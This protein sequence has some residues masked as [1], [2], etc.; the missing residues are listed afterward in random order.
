MSLTSDVTAPPYGGT[1]SFI[2]RVFDD[3]GIQITDITPYGNDPVYIYNLA[4]PG[5]TYMMLPDDR[6][7][8]PNS[9]Y[10]DL[11]QLEAQSFTT[12]NY[13][14]IPLTGTT[15][16]GV[17]L[18]IEWEMPPVD[19]SKTIITCAELAG[20]SGGFSVHHDIGVIP[21]GSMNIEL[22]NNENEPYLAGEVGP[23][24]GL[25]GAFYTLSPSP[26]GL[27]HNTTDIPIAN[28]GFTPGQQFPYGFDT[29][30]IRN[31]ADLTELEGVFSTTL[32]YNGF[33][34]DNSVIQYRENNGS[35]TEV[36]IF[37]GTTGPP[38][39]FNYHIGDVGPNFSFIAKDV[40][41]SNYIQS[42][43]SQYLTHT[44]ANDDSF[45]IDD[46]VSATYW[47]GGSSVLDMAGL[48]GYGVQS[49]TINYS[50]LQQ[51]DSYS[52]KIFYYTFDNSLAVLTSPIQPGK[53]A[54]LGA[55]TVITYDPGPDNTT[56]NNGNPF[57]AT[58]SWTPFNSPMAL[59][60][61]LVNSLSQTA[62]W[63]A[64]Q[65]SGLS[66]TVDSL[67]EP[68][69]NNFTINLSFGIGGVTGN[70]P[71]IP[72][73]A[74][75]FT[76]TYADPIFDFFVNGSTGT[77]ISLP[78][79]Q[80]ASV[81]VNYYTA[82]QPRVLWPFPDPLFSIYYNSNEYPLVPSGTTGNFR[83]N[84]GI[85]LNTA[86]AGSTLSVQARGSGP[87]GTVYGYEVLTY[88]STGPIPCF[89][90]NAPILTPSGNVRIDSLKT[91][92]VLVTNKG[93]GFV[94][95][96]RSYKI[97]ASAVTNPYLIPEGKYGATEDLPISPLHRVQVDTELIAAK[98][99]G[100]EQMQLTGQLHYFNVEL[101][102]WQNM[103]VAGVE[104]DS[105]A[106]AAWVAIVEGLAA[107]K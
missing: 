2:G 24:L 61:P 47:N 100:L 68:G 19:Y 34:F 97:P 11:T 49:Y 106:P 96:L 63:S 102:K 69:T 75:N 81:N 10:Y 26:D 4:N 105:L 107:M 44:G 55:N 25:R 43:I 38:T 32:Y 18:S 53:K 91:G 65:Q 22:F 82:D 94:K 1:V 20:Q 37:Q 39:L 85:V 6:K 51:S 87:T 28:N 67:L 15:W 93:F 35:G 77:N 14:L 3:Q 78:M 86:E 9:F 16:D 5:V 90:G 54:T 29:L 40:F 98:D 8:V 80:P 59:N 99:L 31:P 17:T 42:D 74:P 76:L 45:S 103:F 56:I 12:T 72:P 64:L 89:F 36:D 41:G 46:P 92:D 84:G 30:T 50:D 57:V 52:Y 21:A 66:F 95:N 60:G 62:T 71:G 23:E 13:G 58:L 104:V 48:S 7:I 73:G 101:D 88:G 33:V 70:I 79:T 27:Y 83:V